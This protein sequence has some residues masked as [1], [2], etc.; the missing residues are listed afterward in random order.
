MNAGHSSISS[1]YGLGADQVL[2]TD[3]VTT[4]GEQRTLDAHCAQQDLFWSVRGGGGS[5]FAVLLSV[6]IKTYPV[7]PGVILSYSYNTTANSTIFWNLAAYV[8]S[9]IPS[10]N[11]AGGM[12]DFF[13]SQMRVGLTLPVTGRYLVRKSSPI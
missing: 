13:C 7:L 10:V 9:A 11:D 4:D 8:L 5:N 1:R 3:V 12:R 2:S 6:T